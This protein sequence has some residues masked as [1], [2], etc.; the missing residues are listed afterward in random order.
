VF[1]SPRL[2]GEHKKQ[3]LWLWSEQKGL[4]Q[5]QCAK[6]PQCLPSNQGFFTH[7][8]GGNCAP[9][10]TPS[11][12]A[13]VISPIPVKSPLNKGKRWDFTAD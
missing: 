2:L 4:G 8:L 7:L 12:P 3:E 13:K 1:V 11:S 9:V 5:I 10:R 6:V